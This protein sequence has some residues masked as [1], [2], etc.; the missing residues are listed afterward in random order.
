MYDYIFITN[1]PSFYK[2]NLYNKLAK[3]L[4]IFVIF[5]ADST[6]EKR[7]NDFI[8]LTNADFKYLLINQQE[9]QNRNKFFSIIKLYRVLTHLKYKKLVIGGWDLLELWFANFFSKKNKNCLVVESTIVESQTKGFKGF[10]KRVFLSRISTVFASGKLQSQLLQEL[11]YKNDIKITQGVGIINKPLLTLVKKNKIYQKKFLYVG[12]LVKI[13]NLESLITIFNELPEHQLTII[14]DGEE[15]KAL[16]SIASK[17]IIFIDSIE[18]RKL[19]YNFY[20]N[21]ILILLSLKEV[22]GLVVEESLYFGLP[23]IISQNCGACELLQNG[24]NGYIVNPND[25]ESIKSVITNIDNNKYQ[26]LLTGV[27]D[28][29]V[30]NKDEYQVRQYKF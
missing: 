1:I 27:A 5:I 23:V 3:Q 18:N 24:K 9:L 21:N 26:N 7:S 12:R 8:T 11:N 28:F 15:K 13:K 6:E 22:W 30:D 25:V 17:N 19:K 10:A 14:G 29:S 2:V 20:E 16:K 4:N